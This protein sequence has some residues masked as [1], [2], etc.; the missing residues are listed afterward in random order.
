MADEKTTDMS[1]PYEKTDVRHGSVAVGADDAGAIP[2][3]TLG[4]GSPASIASIVVQEM[5]T[6]DMAFEN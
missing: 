4:M 5:E 1:P 2:K 6:I 3:G